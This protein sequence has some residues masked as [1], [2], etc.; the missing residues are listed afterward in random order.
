[1][2]LWRVR[3][4][5]P[6]AILQVGASR[7][8]GP[9]TVLADGTPVPHGAPILHLHLDNARVRR[10]LAGSRGHAWAL[11]RVL[12]ADLDTLADGVTRGAYGDVVAIRG[13]T[14]LAGMSRRFGFEVRPLPRTFRWGLVHDLAGLVMASYGL[15][16]GIRPARGMPWPGEAWM[17]A[18]ALEARTRNAHG[19]RGI[20][21]RRAG[22]AA[23]RGR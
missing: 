3:P 10:A 22:P 23:R 7:F 13:V 18:R 16:A 6:G 15:P 17:S 2:R 11:A 19:M 8:R 20:G 21:R 9:G 4:V 14:V 5:R 1:M 12:R